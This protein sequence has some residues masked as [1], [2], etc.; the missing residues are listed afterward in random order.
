[1]AGRSCKW[2]TLTQVSVNQVLLD[3]GGVGGA[4]AIHSSLQALTY[5]AH[6]CPYLIAI[7]TL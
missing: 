5:K 3:G 4:Q 6:Q 7:Y 2:R 1:M